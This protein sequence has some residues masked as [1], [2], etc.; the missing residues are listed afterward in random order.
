MVEFME[1]QLV[2]YDDADSEQ[3]E[4]YASNQNYSFWFFN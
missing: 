1:D 3:E 4:K 2:E